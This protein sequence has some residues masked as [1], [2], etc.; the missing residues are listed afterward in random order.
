MAKLYTKTGDR[1]TTGLFD[2]SRVTK[3]HPRVRAYGAIDELNAVL[4]LCRAAC[5]NDELARHIELIQN[6]LF[7]L[8]SDLATPL[9]AAKPGLPRAQPEQAERLEAWIDQATDAVP[10]L[11]AFILPGGCEAACRLHHARTV[12]RRAERQTVALAAAETINSQV[13]I[14]LNRLG[15]LLFA[16]ARLANHQAGHPETVWKAPQG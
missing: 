9:T 2:G 1:G 10:P 5:T 3:D 11:T 7:I 8:G 12:C 4:G 6:E 16:W 13:V 14:Y 15:D